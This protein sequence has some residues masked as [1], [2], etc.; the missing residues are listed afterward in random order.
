MHLNTD[1][2]APLAAPAKLPCMR[3]M[4]ELMTTHLPEPLVK[5]VPLDELER[6]GTELVNEH[7]RFAE[8]VPLVLA[9]EARRRARHRGLVG[10]RTPAPLL[11]S[12]AY[13]RA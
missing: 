13:S 7:P 1:P 8:E 12:Q 3:D 10:S 2:P 9:G 4:H 11:T 6:R 5:L